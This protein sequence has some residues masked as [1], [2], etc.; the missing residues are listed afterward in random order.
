MNEVRR[1][2]IPSP[3]VAV[4]MLSPD[5]GHCRGCFRTIEEIAGW[6]RMDRDQR[7]ACLE[8]L[9]QR[10]AEEEARRRANPDDEDGL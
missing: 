4:C 8:R 7:L 1:R 9:E 5:T 6:L 2:D 10:R 3:C